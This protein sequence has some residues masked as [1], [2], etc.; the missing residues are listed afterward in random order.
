[1][2]LCV[3]VWVWDKVGQHNKK[4]RRMHINIIALKF[5]WP[6][7]NHS[8]RNY[9]HRFFFFFLLFILRPNNFIFL[10][11]GEFIFEFPDSGCRC[12]TAVKL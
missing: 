6:Q 3:Y 1:M 11:C 10:D 2:P 4:E 7:L 5:E 12:L 8:T 9:H